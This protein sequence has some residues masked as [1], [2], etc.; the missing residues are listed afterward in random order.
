MSSTLKPAPNPEQ[1]VNDTI[2]ALKTPRSAAML[3]DIERALRQAPKDAR[4]WHLKGLIHRSQDRR[5]LAIPALQRAAELAPNVPLIAHGLARTLSEAGLPSVDAYARALQLS[6]G[7]T[8]LLAGLVSALIA[9]RR[10]ADAIAGLERGLERSPQWTEGHELLSNLRW[11]EGE[12]DGFARSFDEALQ[13][14]PGDLALR[15]QQIVTL[16]HAELYDDV[17]SRIAE[18]RRT[19][20]DNIL[21]DVNEAIVWS[22]TGDP[23][24]AGSLF[25]R[26]KDVADGSA[27]I[28]RVRHLLRYGRPR[29]AVA[30]ME[31][32]L[33]SAEA[34]GFWPY[35]A[36]AWRM[37]GDPRSEWLEGD[38]RFVGIYDIAD[39]LPPLDRLADTLRALHTTKG[40]P[41]VQS[42]RGG[43][44]TDGHLFQLI[45][46]T[47]VALREAIRETVREHVARL[48][49][50]DPGHPLLASPREPVAFSGAWSVRLQAGGFHS[51]H[52]HPMGWISSALYIVLPPDLGEG[53]AGWLALGEPRTS[54]FPI[55]LPPTRLIE[56]K[57]GRLALF[58]SWMWHGTRPFGA[59]ERLTVAFDVAVPQSA[60]RT[61]RP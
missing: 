3:P 53:E 35:A 36:T 13:L 42:V 50:R 49:A 47:I 59:G 32:W 31:P 58:P 19:L 51:N 7:N 45:D 44:Q 1:V 26:V 11:L 43:T 9:E 5:E 21:F 22:E 8:T 57:P 33:K 34:F 61:P 27:Q 52:V 10:I 14:H 60:Q 37:T 55:D 29:D 15:R 48:P 20:G 25:E 40:Q 17:L 41:L 4:L 28:R 54:S 56:P 16:L 6:P 18:G 24:R 12:R 39:R 46:P 2:A 23:E 38:E 30:V